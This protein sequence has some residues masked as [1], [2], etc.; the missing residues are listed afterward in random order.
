MSSCLYMRTDEESSVDKDLSSG[1][2]NAVPGPRDVSRPGSRTTRLA[3]ALGSTGGPQRR[4]RACDV[5]SPCPIPASRAGRNNVN[6]G[7]GLRRQLVVAV[8]A[9]IDAH[10]AGLSLCPARLVR[11][12]LA[13][14]DVLLA[15]LNLKLTARPLKVVHADLR[16][17]AYKT[18]TRL[19]HG[20]RGTSRESGRRRNV[21]STPAR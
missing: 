12:A 7:S 18:N 10:H 20:N 9:P 5:R 17:S 11:K 19:C 21:G 4:R 16:H 2:K 15:E 14:E 13:P 1:C 6:D 3:C 8:V